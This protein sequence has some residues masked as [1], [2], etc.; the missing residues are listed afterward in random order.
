MGDI[1]DYYTEQGE[2]EWILHCTGQ[3]GQDPCPYCEDLLEE[4][5]LMTE[6]CVD[7]VPDLIEEME[8]DS[9]GE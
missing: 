2:D 4:A 8:K 9:R 5:R 1:A 7:N 3:C 6:F